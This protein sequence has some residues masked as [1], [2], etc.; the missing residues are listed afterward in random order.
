M[1]YLPIHIKSDHLYYAVYY[2]SHG[3]TC[4]IVLFNDKNAVHVKHNSF[5]TFLT[6]SQLSLQMWTPWICRAMELRN[7]NC[8]KTGTAGGLSRNQ[9]NG[10]TIHFY[11]VFLSE[12]KPVTTANHLLERWLCHQ[13]TRNT[14]MLCYLAELTEQTGKISKRKG[15]DLHSPT[16]GPTFLAIPNKVPALL[17]HLKM[18]I[19]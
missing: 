14:Y 18:L 16:K 9:T 5:Q 12:A 2:K 8:N 17:T 4:Y 1:H 11:W 3:N 7:S 6:H 15:T 19:L 10:V 13:L